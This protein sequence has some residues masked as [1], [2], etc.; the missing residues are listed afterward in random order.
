ML[1]VAKVGKWNCLLVVRS[2]LDVMRGERGGVSSREGA[3]R[4]AGWGLWVTMVGEWS[5]LAR[6]VEAEVRGGE[7]GIVDVVGSKEG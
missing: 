1:G 3:T 4:V 5:C 7:E 2:A 6:T